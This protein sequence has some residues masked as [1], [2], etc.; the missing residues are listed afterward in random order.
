MEKDLSSSLGNK[1]LV[2]SYPKIFFSGV[3]ARGILKNLLVESI[4]NNNGNCPS[5]AFFDEKEVLNWIF[6]SLKFN[7]LN[8]C[9]LSAKAFNFWVASLSFSKMINLFSKKKS[10]I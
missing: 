6:V 5:P 10:F 3:E 7:F 1:L 8:M 4:D 2:D 9:S